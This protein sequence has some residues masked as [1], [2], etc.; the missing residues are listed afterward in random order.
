MCLLNQEFE[1]T[2]LYLLQKSFEG[3]NYSSHV[4]GEEI[5]SCRLIMAKVMK[6]VLEA[7]NKFRSSVL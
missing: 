7:G 1:V 4:V 2:V 5:G 3:K 6:K